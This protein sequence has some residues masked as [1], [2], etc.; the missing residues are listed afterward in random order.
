MKQGIRT[1]K[2]LFDD[3]HFMFVI[4]C[5]SLLHLSN[6]GCWVTVIKMTVGK[7]DCITD[8]MLIGMQLPN[9]VE[10]ILKAAIAPTLWF[11]LKDTIQSLVIQQAG[12]GTCSESRS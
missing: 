5:I 4:R 7:S 8:L 9:I 3:L 2:L 6:C 10:S 1:L 12:C 11:S